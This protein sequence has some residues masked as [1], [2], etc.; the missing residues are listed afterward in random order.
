MKYIKGNLLDIF[1]NKQLDILVHGCNCFHTMGAGIA[2]QIKEKYNE[3]YL[4]DLKTIKGDI[5][6]LGDYSYV[7]LKTNQYII[8]GYT[9]YHYSG[10]KPIDYNALR[11]VFKIINTQFKN[12]IIGIPKI[13]S[14]LAKGK[15]TIIEKIINEESTNN[16]IICVLL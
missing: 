9:Q 8:N 11:N 5:N 3:A 15:W 13:G 14:G 10:K 7:K 6:K 1:H 4:A 12:K 16:I 2:K